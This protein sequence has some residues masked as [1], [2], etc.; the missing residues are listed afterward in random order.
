M[1]G[2]LDDQR[3]G[4]SDVDVHLRAVAE[5]DHLRHDSCDGVATVP[6]RLVGALNGDAFGP[7]DDGRLARFGAP[8]DRGP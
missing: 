6:D 5:V 8:L 7:D 1:V 2:H 3:N 4:R